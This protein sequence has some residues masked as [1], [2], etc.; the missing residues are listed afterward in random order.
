MNFKSDN[1]ATVCPEILEAICEANHG[2]SAS[3]SNDDYTKRLQKQVDE[4][5]EIQTSIFFTNTGTAANSLALSALVPSYGS[6]FCHS[7]AHIQVDECNGPEF[8]THGAKLLTIEGD[9]GKISPD[10]LVTKIEFHRSMRP[11]MTNPYALS[12]TQATECGTVYY[13]DKIKE[14]TNIAKTYDLSVHMDGARFA[15]AVITLGMSPADM[16]WRSG[17][18]VLCFG[19]TKNGALMAEM[20]IFF[21]QKYTLDFDYRIKRSGQLMSKGRFLAAQFLTLFEDNLWLKNANH[22]NQMAKRLEETLRK[23]PGV[24]I[25]NPVEANEVF[26]FIPAATAGALYDK[27][28]TFYAWGPVDQNIYRFVTSWITDPKEIAEL[29]SIVTTFLTST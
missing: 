15:N 10:E 4:I 25:V 8:F 2:H 13:P 20:I 18:D 26:A 28:A 27:G 24:F 9:N 21:N 29:E 6:I 7:E 12:L 1:T 23:I 22:A 16:T 19:G 3:Y 14:L 5:F 11:H 17:V